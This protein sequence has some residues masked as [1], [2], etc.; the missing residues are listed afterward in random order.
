MYQSP[1]LGRVNTLQEKTL[2]RSVS[3]VFERHRAVCSTPR[4]FRAR[5]KKDKIKRFMLY[6]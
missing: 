3:A 5:Q 2:A 1:R 4:N 6:A